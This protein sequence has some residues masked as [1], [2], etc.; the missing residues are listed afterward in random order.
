MRWAERYMTVPFCDLGRD[1]DGCDCWGLVRLVYGHELGIELSE[2]GG[3]N[4]NDV[5][6]VVRNF[7]REFSAET[8]HRAE[9]P[10][11]FDVVAMSGGY[12]ERKLFSHC[13]V[14]CSDRVL[15]D[16]REETG[17]ITSDISDEKTKSL[18]IGFYRH[19]A[20]L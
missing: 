8:W 1:W 7:R 14:M 17:V 16:T 10:R 18:V 2:H 11:A 5:T 15:M 19:G 4:V 13:G 12:G 20:L 3:I 6:R 9:A